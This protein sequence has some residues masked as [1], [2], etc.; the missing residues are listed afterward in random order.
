MTL[1]TIIQDASAEIGLPR[2]T[3]VMAA[4]DPTVRALLV[5]ANEEGQ[6]LAKAHDWQAL[7]A[8]Q[9]FTS[10]ATETQTSMI[11]AAFGHFIDGT[12]W[13]RTRRRPLRGPV[14]P[15]EWQRIKAST[16]SPVVDTFTYRNNNILISPVPSAGL[17]FA[18]EYV[19]EN[20]CASSGGTGQTAWAADTDVGVLPERLIRLGIVWRF[21]QARG[22]SY[23]ADYSKYMYAIRETMAQDS[24]HDVVDFADAARRGPGLVIPEGD[25]VL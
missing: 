4:T 24:P 10:V 9:T 5:A 2:P 19:S 14:S 20:W 11:P 22:M 16:T 13:N 15:Q 12:F 7:R 17:T 21:K 3:G 1:L 25:W 8:E 23:D 6:A 18:F